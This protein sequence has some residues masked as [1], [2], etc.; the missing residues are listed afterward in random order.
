MPKVKLGDK[1]TALQQIVSPFGK[2]CTIS[3]LLRAWVIGL[4]VSWGLYFFLYIDTVTTSYYVYVYIYVSDRYGIS[5]VWGDKLH[6]VAAW[7]SAGNNLDSTSYLVIYWSFFFSQI[8]VLLFFLLII[9]ESYRKIH[10][11]YCLFIEIH[12]LYSRFIFPRDYSPNIYFLKLFSAPVAQVFWH[13]P[14]LVHVYVA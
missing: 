1:I 3:Y 14:F 2:V 7:T 5:S 11:N 9:P 8:A 4:L 6:Q 10:R 12:L 13:C